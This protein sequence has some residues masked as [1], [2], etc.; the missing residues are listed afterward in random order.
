MSQETTPTHG[1]IYKAHVISEYYRQ[2]KL[3]KGIKLELLL[4][5]SSF[6]PRWHSQ[7]ILVHIQQLV[8]HD[9]L[10]T[11]SMPLC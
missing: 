10:Y 9:V 8:L 3:I 6:Q 4:Y 7:A 1:T 2:L 11:P 5:T